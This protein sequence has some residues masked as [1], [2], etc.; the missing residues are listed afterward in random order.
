MRKTLG[1]AAM[2]LLIVLLTAAR[3]AAAPRLVIISWD[4]NAN[5][6]VA[7]L[8]RG[9]KLPNVE[10]L[11]QRGVRAEYVTPAF[12]SKTAP[13]HAAIWTGAYSDINGVS[14]NSVPLLPRAE[15]TLLEQQDGFD[16][17]AL[18]AEPIW[19]T[20]LLAGK[21]VVG[22]SATHMVPATPYL[23]AMK[24]ASIPAE[25]FMSFDEFRVGIATA[26]VSTAE[27]LVPATA[28]V[29]ARIS[30]ERA[31]E[32][33]IQVGQNRFYVL[34]Y[35]SPDDPVVGFD[36]VAVC[37]DRKQMTAE[38]TV[39]KPVEA[40]DS[41]NQ[42]SKPFR[43]TKD[44]LFGLTSFRLFSLSKAGD[45]M[46]LYQR[47]SAG[48]RS[49]ASR[50]LTEEY[51]RAAGG[52]TDTGF[53]PYERGALGPP[54]WQKGDGI[55]EKRL[56][57][58]VRFDLEMRARR[59]AFSLQR[60]NPDLLFDYSSATDDAGHTWVGALD[61]ESGVYDAA[62]ADKLWPYYEA[63]FRL[64][65]AWLGKII[66]AA[67][68]NAI[69]SLVGDHGMEGTSRTFY[70]NAVLE[71]A[72]L[73]VRTADGKAIDLAKT[74]ICAPRWGDYFVEVNSTDWKG[75]IV[76]PAERDDV[77]RRAMAALLAATDPENGK[78]IVTR[79]FRPEEVVGLGMGGPAGGDLYLD[80]APGYAPSAGLSTDVVR[81]STSAIGS[82]THGFFPL[83]TMM[84]T[85]WFVAGPGIASSGK[86]IG[87]IRQIDIAPTL[88]Q[89]LGIPVPRDAKGHILAEVLTK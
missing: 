76:L 54:I 6:V 68:P 14:G 66:D 31:K 12:P 49:T 85:V 50:E 22:A 11:A 58:I 64:Q 63:V 20:A 81:K 30:G 72:G 3:P 73:L 56:I 44:D 5:W 57:E 21:T 43:V 8:L 9:H 48:F 28:W 65:D 51:L 59:D 79:I 83:R 47:A 88:S 67:G 16:S 74:R 60:L 15:H 82:G 1:Y 87:G 53:A 27:K 41:T 77:I 38:C 2:G 55:A 89:A 80:L 10:R 40:N 62:I 45:Q 36:T 17:A 46:T 32:T 39:L 26:S 75:G 37:P 84:Q 86:T 71:R 24:A 52:S 4:A 7:R 33:S 29:G 34:V 42:W 23:A 18:R 35:D 78:R 25:R 70:P 69:I 61:P 19:L 13:G